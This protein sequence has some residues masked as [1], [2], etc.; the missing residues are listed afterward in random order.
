[1]FCDGVED[2][3]MGEDEDGELCYKT[4]TV[5]TEKRDEEDEEGSTKV[6]MEKV[7]PGD[8]S[9]NEAYFDMTIIIVIFLISCV[10]VLV[11]FFRALMKYFPGLLSWKPA[12][13][14]MWIVA[15][16]SPSPRCSNWSVWSNTIRRLFFSPLL[17]FVDTTSLRLIE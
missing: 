6:R 12:S 2:C 11:I 9:I 4:D 1:M 16:D 3:L 10:S 13:V 15:I 14:S 17:D 5:I 8:Y 7:D